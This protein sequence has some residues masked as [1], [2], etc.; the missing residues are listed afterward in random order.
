MR[1][2]KPTSNLYTGKCSC[3]RVHLLLCLPKALHCYAPRTCDCN[4][5]LEHRIS[6]LSDP[7]GR[8]T[9]NCSSPLVELKQGSQQ[10]SFLSCCHCQAVVAVTVASIKGTKGALNANLLDLKTSLLASL[11]VSPK[12]LTGAQKMTRWNDK[13][14]HTTIIQNIR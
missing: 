2:N 3:A 14:M 12:T 4:F 9:V 7:Q 6:Y 10:A 11:T 13:W 8:L 1:K 5:C